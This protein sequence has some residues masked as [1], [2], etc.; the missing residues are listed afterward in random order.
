MSLAVRRVRSRGLCHLLL[1]IWPPLKPPAFQQDPLNLGSFPSKFTNREKN[2]AKVVGSKPGKNYSKKRS[3]TN[4]IL[5][6][7]N[8]EAEVSGWVGSGAGLAV[9]AGITLTGTMIGSRWIG[10]RDMRLTF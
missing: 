2:N 1:S 6:P 8:C 5:A 9:K 4:E 10:L 3:V 7:I